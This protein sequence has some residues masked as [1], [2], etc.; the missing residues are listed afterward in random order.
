MP[1]TF[2]QGNI[3]VVI[4]IHKTLVKANLHIPCKSKMRDQGFAHIKKTSAPYL[5]HFLPVLFD[6]FLLAVN[7]M[8][9]FYV[10]SLFF[11]LTGQFFN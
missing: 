5:L 11:A 4:R 10:L 6:P 2:K 3:R 1:D 9:Y 8:G 7:F